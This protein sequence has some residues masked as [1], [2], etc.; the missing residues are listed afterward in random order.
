MLRP[1]N[2]LF[3]TLISSILCLPNTH[4]NQLLFNTKLKR[5]TCCGAHTSLPNFL[6]KSLD[7]KIRFH[8]LQ[9]IFTSTP[10]WI[11][12]KPSINLQLT[13]LPKKSTSPIT[14]RD[15]FQSLIINH[16]N[17][18]ICY[19]DGSKTNNRTGLAYS[20]NNNLYSKRH[21]NSAS[22][23]TTE[24]QAIYLTLQHILSNPPLLIQP[25]IISDSLAAL[26]TIANT[27]SGHPL[28][29]RIHLLLNTCAKNNSPTSFVWVPS[30]VE[31]PRNE[32]VDKATKAASSLQCINPLLH[33]TKTD[34]SLFIR[35]LINNKWQEQWSNQQ[36]NHLAK[37]KQLH[38][39]RLTNLV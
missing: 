29:F 15:R 3:A 5:D 34:L 39:H 22:G 9:P 27:N 21:R 37:I 7:K 24:L 35:Q 32:R 28:V 17:S 25:T 16:P 18:N 19:T 4:V 13:E 20:I 36:L 10:P 8:C 1:K 31:I 23:I 30:H 12:I 38:G 14:Y 6:Q 33:P 2:S 11:V 26:T